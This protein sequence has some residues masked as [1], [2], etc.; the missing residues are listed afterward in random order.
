MC[1]SLSSLSIVFFA[2]LWGVP[3]AHAVDRA[4]VVVG[5]ERV[6][7]LGDEHKI[8]GAHLR[9]AGLGKAL[10]RAGYD[11]VTVLTGAKASRAGIRAALDNAIGVLEPSGTLLWVFEGHGIGGDYGDAQLL[12]SDSSSDGLDVARLPAELAEKLGGRSLVVVTDAV[13]AGKHGDTALI[14]PL[15]SDWYALGKQFAAISS[16]GAGQVA[17]SGLFIDRLSTAVSGGADGDSDGKV[18]VSELVGYLRK[19]VGDASGGRMHPSRAGGLDD[20]HVLML[21]ATTGVVPAPVAPIVPAPRGEQVRKGRSAIRPVT[22][23]TM[24]AGAVLGTTS[25]VMYVTKQSSCEAIRLGTPAISSFS[26]PW[27]GR[28]AGSYLRESASTSL[29]RILYRWDQARCT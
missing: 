8:D 18:T 26:T 27:V 10:E 29:M 14:G 3:E 16:T 25:V 13:H 17:T 12:G 5:I 21:P 11:K 28:V 20:G 15:A 4:A 6:E 24:A 19:A 2:L 23:V 1:R 9:A 22:F 7:G